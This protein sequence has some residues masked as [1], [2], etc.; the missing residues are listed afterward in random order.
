M[1]DRKRDGLAVAPS[2]GPHRFKYYGDL[3]CPGYPVYKIKRR[4]PPEIAQG[5]EL[6]SGVFYSFD[7]KERG[8][9]MGAFQPEGDFFIFA[10]NIPSVL[11]REDQRV[12]VL[13]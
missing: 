6:N 8:I 3:P 12:P 13:T 1:V 2:A 11:L 10:Q 4:R 7:R 5:I 9:W